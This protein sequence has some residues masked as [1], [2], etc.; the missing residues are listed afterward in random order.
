MTATPDYSFVYDT[1]FRFLGRQQIC[2]YPV[3][4]S[5][6]CKALH[7]HMLGSAEA[8]RRTGLS[9]HDIDVLCGNTDGAVFALEQGGHLFHT[10]VYNSAQ[11]ILRQRFTIAEECA[12][13]LLKHTRDVRF[14]AGSSLYDENFYQVCEREARAAAGLL[15]CSPKLLQLCA[16]A[17]KPRIV[18][19]ACGIS[20]GCAAVR[21]AQH[22][23]FGEQMC[24]SPAYA[25]L[26]VPV[27]DAPAARAALHRQLRE[28]AFARRA[29]KK[30]S[31]T[32]SGTPASHRPRQEI[33]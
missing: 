19:L 2:H 30:L 17:L 29:Q 33:L 31:H 14:N 12:H 26:P 18:A 8:A 22:H 32:A 1:V 11:P 9:F 3:D 21:I 10:L 20:Q 15:L 13:V 6:I 7:I 4:L 27:I 28:D 16:H 25:A 5:A 23:A 24:V